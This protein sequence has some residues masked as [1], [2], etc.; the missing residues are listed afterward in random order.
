MWKM[1]AKNPILLMAVL[2][3]GWL[4]AGA[5]NYYV[6][7]ISGNDSYTAAQAQN[8]AT[9][10]KTI[11]KVNS[12]FASLNPGDQIFLQAGSVFTGPLKVT[13]S[14]TSG[15]PITISVYGT[16]AMPIITG[17]QTLSGWV[18]IGGGI[19]QAPCVGGLGGLKVNMVAIQGVSTPMGRY[20]NAG[21]AG[22]GYLKVQTF[23]GTTSITDSHLA[24][25]NWSGGNVVIRKN[26]WVIENDAI[27]S[28]SGNTLN[29]TTGSTNAPTIKFGYFIQNHIKTLDQNGEWFYDKVAHK[30]DLYSTTN[31]SGMTVQAAVVDTLVY[32]TNAQ[33]V[34]INGIFFQGANYTAIGFMTSNYIT[35]QNCDIKY[36]GVDAIDVFRSNYNTIN[37]VAVDYSNN[38]C[39]FISGNGN[40]IENCVITRTGNI[41]GA[42]L[43]LSSYQAI[44]IQGNNNTAQY[45]TIDTVGYNGIAFM[46]SSNTI[47]HNLVNY[48]CCV[49]DDGGGIYTWSGNSDS[50]SANVT[51][52][53]T[54]N[55]VANGVTCP[56]GTDSSVAAIAHGIYLDENTTKC[57]VTGNTVTKCTAGLF[58]QDCRNVTIESNTFYD[59]AGQLIVRHF[60][61]ANYMTG[62][63]VYNNIAASNANTEY[64]TEMSS[65]ASISGLTSFGYLHNNRYAQISSGSTF[66]LLAFPSLNTTGNFGSWQSAYKLDAG[67]SSLLPVTFLPYTVTSLI[68]GDIATLS[69][70]LTAFAEGLL[71]SRVIAADPVGTIRSGVSYVA[72]FSMTAPDAAHTML[73]FIHNNV[74]PYTVLTPVVSVPTAKGTTN[75]TVV[76]QTTGATTTG[77]LEFMVQNTEAG[78]SVSNITLYQANVTA[79]NPSG[80]VIFQYNASKSAISVGLTSGATFQDLWG[81]TYTGSASVPAYGSILLIKKT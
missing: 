30:M 44:T 66:Y 57:D 72:K 60:T 34:V 75:N 41:P 53:V 7:S 50:T 63:N 31:P 10:W 5:T 17:F 45:N 77:A 36:S 4:S 68:G 21:T 56:A 6:S 1:N 26:R 38:D 74:S 22:G 55:I 28:Q 12:F 69:S 15:H 51:G 9:P 79:N 76:F 27:V 2:L 67:G 58:Y 42:G 39:F 73:V 35:I 59:N 23:S 48:F 64:I 18:S 80:N 25:S 61:A 65:C 70:I 54:N 8:Q 16:G 37:S 3:T 52:W 62:N 47:S 13:K 20:P 11:A 29:Y 71:N 81:N 78:I 33:Y 14:G 32:L 40:M 19:W 46:G 43:P 24:G 49:K